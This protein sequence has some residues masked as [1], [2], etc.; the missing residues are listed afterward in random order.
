LRQQRGLL[1][2]VMARSIMIAAASYLVSCFS[3]LIEEGCMR[4]PNF[5]ITD[6]TESKSRRFFGVVNGFLALTLRNSKLLPQN[7]E[8]N[9]AFGL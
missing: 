6:A 3:A 7:G 8:K 1:R 9:V 2:K 5:T 4:A